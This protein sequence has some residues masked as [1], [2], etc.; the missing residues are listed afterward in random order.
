MS[1]LKVRSLKVRGQYSPLNWFFCNIY[2]W[3]FVKM[4]QKNERTIIACT[5]KGKFS[6]MN[7]G[8]FGRTF[9]PFCNN[10]WDQI[11]VLNTWFHNQQN[12]EIGG[13]NGS[14]FMNNVPGILIMELGLKDFV[15]HHDTFFF[16]YMWVLSTNL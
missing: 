8:E 4:T 9:L 15:T 7:K 6:F 13:L 2:W 3:P 12:F 5:W 1:K 14:K 16:V 10:V 11:W